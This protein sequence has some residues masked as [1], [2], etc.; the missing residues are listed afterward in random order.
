MTSPK[1]APPLADAA[2]KFL[3][4]LKVPK[5]RKNRAEALD[6]MVERFGPGA[7]L[8]ELDPA[9]VADWIAERWGDFS[10]ATHNSRTGAI[11]AAYTWWAER[12]WIS[13]DQL[14]DALLVLKRVKERAEWPSEIL[15]PDELQALLRQVTT[16]YDTGIRNRALIL[17]MYMAGLRVSEVLSLR[18]SDVSIDDHSIRL[19]QTKS[20][21]PQTR[22]F[23]PAAD[24]AL[25]RWLDR[26]RAL[27]ING[28]S[29]LFSALYDKAGTD[30]RSKGQPLSET[31]VRD[32]LKRYAGEAGITKRVHPH[33][34]RHSFAVWLDS[35]GLSPTV[36]SELLGQSGPAVAQR[37]LKHLSNSEARRALAGISAP[38][39]EP[40]KRAVAPSEDES[41]V[42]RAL[43]QQIASLL[44]EPGEVKRGSG[45]AELRRQVAR[46]QEQVQQ[47]LEQK[48]S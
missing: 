21:Q 26:R 1:P 45:E 15:T 19:R 2:A 34:L 6:P 20:G 23:L 35:Q 44:T 11:R 47:L 46:L 18:P 12:R 17:L 29:P 13:R 32:I 40:R 28:H 10:A 36:I 22:G 30:K 4:S 27:G 33:M 37:Y 16:T 42:I 3:D 24:D 5:T 41:R 38:T 8:G 39:V 9:D 7:E 31:Y 25:L 43:G 48:G 14:A